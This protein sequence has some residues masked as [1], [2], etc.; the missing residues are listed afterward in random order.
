MRIISND[1][2]V[3][4]SLSCAISSIITIIA[5]LSLVPYCC[6]TGAGAVLNSSKT[7]CLE[8]PKDLSYQ[9]SVQYSVM[10]SRFR[11]LHHGRWTV[12]VP[13]RHETVQ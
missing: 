9:D 7:F 4:L 6:S 13:R 1:S 12:H 8:G 2:F 10:D 5:L 11:L 3:A